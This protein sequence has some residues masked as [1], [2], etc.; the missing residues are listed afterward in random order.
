MAELEDIANLPGFGPSKIDSFRNA[1]YE[2]LED[3]RGIT[4]DE[5]GDVK[6]IK[7]SAKRRAILNFLEEHNLREKP[8][9]EEKYEKFRSLLEQLFQFESADLDFGVYRIMNEK[10]DR[11]EDFLDEEL[12]Q[13]VKNELEMFQAT[14]QGEAQEHLEAIK[15]QIKEDQPHWFDKHGNIDSEKLPDNPPN[16]S[17]AQDQK[18]DYLE[19]KAEAEKAEIGEGTEAA[20]Y[21]DL[22]RFFKRYYEDGDFI[23]QRRAANQ[24]KYAIPYNG[25]EV[26]LHWANKDQYFVK[27]GEQF[28]DYKFRK[29][30][31][32]IEFKLHNAHVEKSNK[33]GDDKYFVL[34]DRSPIEQEDRH[35]TVH[36]EY[37]PLRED[38]YDKYDLSESSQTKSRDIQE[39]IKSKILSNASSQLES[40]LKQDSESEY[41]NSTVIEKHLKNYRSKNE[42]DY[43]IHKNLREFLEK[44]LD[45]YLKNE[46]FAWKELRDEKGEIPPRVRARIDAVDNIAKEIINFVSQI[47]DFQKKLYE[48]KKFVVNT[49]YCVTLDKVPEELYPDIL[50]NEAQI[51]DWKDLYALNEKEGPAKSTN[52]EID[53][54][55]V[56]SHPSI[57]IDTKY[58][59]EE[60]KYDLLEHFSNLENSIDGLLIKGEN[61]QSLN[62][63]KEKFSGDIDLSYIDPPYNTGNTFPY[64]DNYKHSSWMSM[65]ADRI[66]IFRHLSSDSGL[67]FSSVDDNEFN[68]L[69]LLFE[70]IYG[71][72]NIMGPVIVQVNKGGRNYVPIAKT[73]EYI[74]VAATGAEKK[75]NN[76]P[77]KDTSDF[78]FE[79]SRSSWTDRG[80]R[81][82]NPKFDRD[83]RPNLYYPIYVDE[84]TTNEYGHAAVSLEANEDSVKIYPKNSAG[85]DDCW[86]WGKEKLEE[87]VIE[88]D[89]D[90]SNVVAKKRRDG[91]W[92]V[93]EKYR[94]QT[95][96]VKSLWDESEMRTESGTIALRN[97]FGESGLYSHPKPVDLV[98]KVLITGSDPQDNVIDFFGGS[99]TTAQAAIELA[100]EEKPRKYTLIEV[101]DYFD[102]LLLPRI[103]KSVYASEWDS[104]KPTEENELSHMIKYHKIEDYEDSLN[105]LDS[106]SQQTDMGEFTSDKL[107][108]H[109]NF[110]VEGPSLLDIEQMKNPFNYEMEIRDGDESKDRDIDL[111]ETFNYLLGL[112]VRGIQQLEDNDRKYRIVTGERD[113]DKITV[114]WRPVEDDDGEEFFEEDREFLKSNVLGDEDIVYINYDSALPDAKSIENTFQNR[115]WE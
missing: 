48:K 16:G 13:K 12:Q 35:L 24:E 8:E 98:K 9:T 31:Y 109:L 64:K 52:Q 75:V 19:A 58:F 33:K 17:R 114:V 68:R 18:N 11:I 94:D 63:I 1:G 4:W 90:A 30:S 87:N 32:D 65:M 73:H 57:V 70:D 44:E 107:E 38:D 10:R 62:L 39:E 54:D 28:K 101:A 110:E 88:G 79:D 51:S 77:K 82:R 81:N 41:N 5:L 42:E 112:E 106:N 40:V 27:T 43:F 20:I 96:Q 86:R 103:K 69:N 26:K 84:N 7:S 21:Q 67:L 76:V 60:F 71:E 59:S 36:F 66:S 78:K 47:E 83:N 50:D 115:M 34:R 53:K 15:N 92:K 23:P 14:E 3:L 74:S 29:D 108:Y 97:M 95:T 104:G 80:L 49:E 113:N 85:K 56:E 100:A 22:Y 93:V 105:N 102:D 72:E 45:F 61:F 25:E 111:I 37:R 46:I 55:F 91:T 99:G 89:I 2:S 6:G